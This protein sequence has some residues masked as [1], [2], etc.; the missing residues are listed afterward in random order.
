MGDNAD[1]LPRA[2]WV[3]EPAKVNTVTELWQQVLPIWSR[4]LCIFISASDIVNAPDITAFLSNRYYIQTQEADKTYLLWLH[5]A[6]KRRESEGMSF[7][8]DTCWLNGLCCPTGSWY[9]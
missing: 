4:E 5:R 3:D 7:T 9:Q 2:P 8:L 6:M 1:L